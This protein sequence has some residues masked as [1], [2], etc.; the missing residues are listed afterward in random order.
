MA[1]VQ[2]LACDGCGTVANQAGVS[3]VTITIAGKRV[4][5]DCCQI[6]IEPVLKLIDGHGSNKRTGRSSGLRGGQII[7]DPSMI[8]KDN[9]RP[10]KVAK[11]RS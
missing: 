11:N 10:R 7:A 2:M 3:K 4:T 6:C 9:P 8:V 1:V 5:V